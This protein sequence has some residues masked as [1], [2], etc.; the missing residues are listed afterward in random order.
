MHK[1]SFCLAGL[2]CHAH[3]DF[4]QTF[5]TSCTTSMIT[6]VRFFTKRMPYSASNM[7]HLGVSMLSA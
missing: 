1:F 2:F 6:E 4:S 3:H 7:V 5:Q